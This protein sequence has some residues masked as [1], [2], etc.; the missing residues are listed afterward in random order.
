MAD[1]EVP[2]D[3]VVT[4]AASVDGRLD[5]PGQP[6]FHRPRRLRRRGPLAQGRR[7]DGARRSRPAARSSSSTTP[8]AP[9]CRRAS[10]RSPATARSS[11]P[12]CCSPGAVPQISLI[13][14]PCAGGAAYSPGADRL[15]HPDSPGPDVH[16]RAAGHQAGDRRGDHR[17][18]ARRR[19]RPHGP[20]RRHPLHR[21]GRRGGRS[22]SAAACSAS[23]RRTIWKTRRALPSDEQRR[24][25]PR[26][27]RR[28]CRVDP[29]QG[30]DVRERDLRHRRPAATSSRSRPATP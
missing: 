16:H 20:L 12:T 23:C 21:R 25:Q 22:T 15:H 9:A 30:Y 2:A 10:T 4:G 18:G 24:S 26:A 6:G 27:D 7:R 8:A 5:P 13:C 3:G 19:R 28:S 1:K 11:T 17:R 29:K 14:G